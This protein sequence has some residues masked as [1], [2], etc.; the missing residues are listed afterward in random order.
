MESVLYDS[1]SANSFREFMRLIPSSSALLHTILSI[2]AL[3]QAQRKIDGR[4]IKFQQLLYIENGTVLERATTTSEQPSAI[5]DALMHKQHALR[6]MQKELLNSD[7]CNFDGTIASI[8]LLVWQDL[9]E[10]GIDSWRYHLDALKGVVQKRNCSSKK[11][12]TKMQGFGSLSL[13]EHFEMTYATFQVLGTTFVRT[14]QSYH[15]LF[16]TTPT[17]QIMKLSDGQSWAGCPAELLYVIS[18]LNNITGSQPVTSGF[19]THL[20]STFEDF[21]PMKW[22]IASESPSLMKP[23]YHFASAYK[24]AV[25]IYMYQVMHEL[26]E[27]NSVGIPIAVSIDSIILHI[28][29]LCHEDAHFKCLVWPAFVIG[30]EARQESQ[31]VAIIQVFEH[32]WTIWRCQNV[33]NALNVLTDLWARHDQRGYSGPWIGDI[34]GW[35]MDWIFI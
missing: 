28:R 24:E 9:M 8:L 16:S 29:S 12:N 20:L 6:H 33:K 5:Y 25:A 14:K 7:F 22:A 27:R 23:R 18:L 34:H 21:S 31:R 32:L 10:S 17:I 19:K 30:A 26:C 35:G 3:H 2:A 15:P 13:Y 4:Y 1:N 11:Q